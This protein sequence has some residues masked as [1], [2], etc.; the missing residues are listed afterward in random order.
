M[1]DSLAAMD[2]EPLI[3]DWLSDMIMYNVVSVVPPIPVASHS[4]C[5]PLSKNILKPRLISGPRR[6]VSVVECFY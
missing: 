4:H 5:C 6:D 3:G 2:D 1:W